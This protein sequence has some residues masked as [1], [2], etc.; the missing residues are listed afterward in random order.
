MHWVSFPICFSATSSHYFLKQQERRQWCFAAAN[1]EVLWSRKHSINPTW[2]YHTKTGRKVHLS[3]KH[4][5]FSYEWLTCIIT[6][7]LFRIRN[8]VRRGELVLMD[9]FPLPLL[10]I[11]GE[12]GQKKTHHH[13][14]SP[15]AVKSLNIACPHPFYHQGSRRDTWNPSTF[16][17]SQSQLN[18]VETPSLALM[19]NCPNVSNLT[20]A[21]ILQSL[22]HPILPTHCHW[23]GRKK[24]NKRVGSFGKR[25]E[26]VDP[27]P[28]YWNI[29]SA[30]ILNME[31]T[32]S[33]A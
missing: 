31:S 25:R 32:S 10:A 22:S 8:I 19:A 11:S 6:V 18:R 1:L 13:S 26:P 33:P 21:K 12:N 24:N 29:E 4:S 17:Q 30:D 27:I 14:H 5:L 15:K 9:L 2:R 7:F 20:A 16:C 23:A 28:L 3:I